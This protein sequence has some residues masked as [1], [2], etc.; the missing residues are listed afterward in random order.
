M[1]T[2]RYAANEDFVIEGHWSRPGGK[3][4]PAGMLTHAEG[5]LELQLLGAFDDADGPH[6]FA[7]HMPEQEPQVI[8][9]ESADGTLLTLLNCFYTNWQPGGDLQ[10]E[11]P[12]PIRTSKLSCN[13]MILGAHLERDDEPI[14][15]QSSLAIP[16]LSAWLDDSP[17]AV[18]MQG[19]TSVSVAYTMPEKRTF[20]IPHWGEFQFTPAV[21][22]PS[23]PYDDVTIKHRTY[24][25]IKPVAPRNFAW[26]VE[27]AGEIERLFTLLFGRV[28]QIARNRLRYSDNATAKDVDAYLPTDRIAQS[29]MHRMDFLTTYP[30]VASWFP[31]M[32]ESWF[33][34]SSEIRHALDLVFSSLRRPGRFLET[35]F[36][37]FVQA[38]EVYS[39]AVNPGQIVDK[40]VYKPIRETLVG[41]IPTETPAQL[42]EAIVRS[43]GYANDRSLRERMIAL[44]DGML[45]ETRELFCIDAAEFAKGVVDTRNFLTHYSSDPDKALKSTGLH[46]ATIKLQ[47]MMKV[48]LLIKLGI[49]EVE[50]QKIVKRNMSLRQ[51]KKNWVA[52]RELPDKGNTTGESA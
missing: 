18:K 19:V 52:V 50:V 3:H 4:R 16:S 10:Q 24:V 5:T 30:T 13:G 46:W 32:L 8:H 23:M 27:M 15:T 28:V 49:P 17:F 22:P 29:Q 43:L 37:P 40:S 48:L 1:S 6:A 42:R 31:Q 39:R 14:F 21:T 38:V 45:H 35:R 20:V 33:C 11:G 26:F 36:I 41:S 2:E 47:T 12:V 44:M 25:D 7:R 51:E 9:G 34:Q